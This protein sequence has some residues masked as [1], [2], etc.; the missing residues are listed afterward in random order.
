MGRF[1]KGWWHV[2]NV[3]PTFFITQPLGESVCGTTCEVR[4]L[5][6][7]A[8]ARTKGVV[9]RCSQIPRSQGNARAKG[10]E[11]HLFD[12]CPLLPLV[13]GSLG[14]DNPPTD[15]PRAPSPHLA[16]NPRHS[17]SPAM[18]SRDKHFARLRLRWG[19]ASLSQSSLTS[20][21]VSRQVLFFPVLWRSMFA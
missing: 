21:H 3:V 6:S 8:K 19:T 9:I 1:G 7:L 12:S 17:L 14:R 2:K 11:R 4:S 13:A 15:L 5:C 20:L 16:P 18:E 10:K